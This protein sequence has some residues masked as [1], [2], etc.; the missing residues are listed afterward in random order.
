MQNR[1]PTTIQTLGFGL[2]LTIAYTTL[3]QAQITL[4]PTDVS[5]IEKNNASADAPKP[6]ETEA[7]MPTGQVYRSVDANGKVTFTD[8]PPK[9]RP[10]SAV[11]IAEPN[12]LPAENITK[13]VAP[14]TDKDAHIAYSSVSI[15]S[16]QE[17]QTFGNEV[18]SISV[19]AALTPHLQKGDRVQFYL[20]GAAWGEPIRGLHKQLTEIERGTHTIEVSVLDH[21]GH[22]LIASKK[23]NFHIRRVSKL[24][25][26]A[27]DSLN[28]G[29]KGFG[30]VVAPVVGV[31][32]GPMVVANTGTGASTSISGASGF[33]QSMPDKP[34]PSKPA[35]K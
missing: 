25:P 4:P 2:L 30:S 23:V 21:D 20:D 19:N 9:D 32:A 26:H 29:I 18:E 5:A 13:N 24:G 15:T 1:I 17:D 31:G 35:S 12:T 27:S 11:K 34:K 33:G 7:V 22:E 14:N 16:P 8:S 6:N 28:Q 10:S 3:V